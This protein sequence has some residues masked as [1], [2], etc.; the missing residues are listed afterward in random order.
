MKAVLSVMH[1]YN[2]TGSMRSIETLQILY[3]YMIFLDTHNTAAGSLQQPVVCV[4][5]YVFDSLQQD[6]F[7]VT[8][9]QGKAQLEEL[10][11]TVTAAGASPAQL[12]GP[13]AGGPELLRFVRCS[14]ECATLIVVSIVQCIAT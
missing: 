13:A 4:A 1:S 2:L 7:R 3:V 9:A 14:C 6:A 11:C 5:N 8:V 10:L 12:L